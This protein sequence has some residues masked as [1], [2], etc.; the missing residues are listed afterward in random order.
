MFKNTSNEKLLLDNNTG[1][2]IDIDYLR[3]FVVLLVVYHHSII[4]YATFA[5]M[6][7][8]NPIATFSPVVNEKRL[9]LFDLFIA[10]NDVY[11]MQLMFFIS[12]LFV[13]S[14]LNKKGIKKYLI[15]RIRRLAIPFIVCL[16]IIIPLAYYPAVLEVQNM[17]GGD[18]G[19][20]EFWSLMIRHGFGTAGPLWFLW[21]L[22]V[23]DFI[24]A[25]LYYLVPNVD[26]M[27]KRASKMFERPFTFFIVLSGIT[28][29]AYVPVLLIFDSQQWIG[30]GPCTFQASRALMY[31]VYFITGV[32]IGIYG[33]DKSLLSKD[34]LLAKRIWIWTTI[35]PLCFTCFI[36]A[37]IKEDFNPYLK[38]FIFVITCASII[39]CTI[40]VFVKYAHKRFRILDSLNSNAYGIY[41]VHYT[42]MTWLQYGLLR[43]ELNPFFKGTF[44]FI[45]TVILSWVTIAAI[46]M[47]PNVKKVI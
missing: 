44:V 17:Y 4:A 42:F 12:G 3:A 7:P 21:V 16:P 28:T 23:F 9:E 45:G 35:G 20:M 18:T 37:A 39:M 10:Y 34:G 8:V 31:F 46:R 15:D 6:N 11:F 22:L 5:Y 41:I 14:S 38:G 13:W 25:L 40:A 24:A 29:L 27:I 47:I 43:S 32:A 36:L 26:R 1:R 33:L 19:Y 30:I 2:R